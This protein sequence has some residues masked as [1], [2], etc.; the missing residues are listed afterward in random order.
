M[1]ASEAMVEHCRTVIGNRV[2][3]ATFQEYNTEIQFDEIW[4]CASLL[5]LKPR[6]LMLY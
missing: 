6:N 5:H 1:D 2:T 3:L 4:A